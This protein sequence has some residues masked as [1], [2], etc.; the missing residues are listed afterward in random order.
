VKEK[1]EKKSFEQ[2]KLSLFLSSF[3]LSETK[4]PTRKPAQFH[5]TMAQIIKRMLGMEDKS[6]H[7]EH[8]GEEERYARRE[9]ERKREEDERGDRWLAK[10]KNASHHYLAF[11]L[12]SRPRV[13]RSLVAILI[14]TRISDRPFCRVEVVMGN[15]SP[16]PREPERVF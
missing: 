14:P 12:L 15:E 1:R 6:A 10:K 16:K 13:S 7:A 8:K 5:Q 9:G 3:K 4:K 2:K 11:S